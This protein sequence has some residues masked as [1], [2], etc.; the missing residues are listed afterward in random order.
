MRARVWNEITTTR[1]NLE[2]VR[3]YSRLQGMLTKALNVLVLIF[4]SS[5]VLGW[6][7]FQEGKLAGISCIIIAAISVLRMISPVFIYSDKELRKLDKYFNQL[8]TYYDKVESFW[9]DFEE[10]KYNARLAKKNFYKLISDGNKLHSDYGDLSFVYPKR[11]IEKA[12]KNTT[13][14]LSSI[15]NT[16]NH[17]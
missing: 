7:V 2:Y 17:E 6:A 13:L 16:G 10:G 11:L 9:F 14:Y 5:G 12:D 8:C 1:H 4:S 15:F 3:I